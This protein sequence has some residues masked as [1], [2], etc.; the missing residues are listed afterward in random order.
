MTIGTECPEM[1]VFNIVAPCAMRCVSGRSKIYTSR[2]LMTSEMPTAGP[3]LLLR[4]EL[5]VRGT[6]TYLSVHGQML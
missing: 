1:E 5:Y 3:G 2:Y 4:K 6:D